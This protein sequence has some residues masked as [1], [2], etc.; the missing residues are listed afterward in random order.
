MHPSFFLSPSFS[1]YVHPS[2]PC[3][4]QAAANEAP[5]CFLA[6]PLNGNAGGVETPPGY[7]PGVYAAV[8]A[9]GGLCI[10]DE[11]Q[12]G[13]GR[14]GT[15]EWGFEEHGVTPDIVTVRAC[16]GVCAVCVC[17]RAIFAFSRLNQCVD[18]WS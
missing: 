12:V 6:E 16:G 18:V 5:A 14:L 1:L 11:V 17:E 7:F 15:H 4:H 9:T 2:P 3:P 10:A 8:R 13:L